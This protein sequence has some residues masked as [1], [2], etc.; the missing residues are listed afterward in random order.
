MN[1][2]GTATH[3]LTGAAAGIFAAWAMNEFQNAWLK[4][5]P[6]AGKLQTDVDIMREIA[7]RAAKATGARLSRRQLEAAGWV[8]HYGFGTTAGALY[9]VLAEKSEFVTKGFGAGFGTVFFA[10]GDAFAPEDLKPKV[11][12]SRTVS[13]IYEWLTHVVYGVALEAGRRGAL[14]GLKKLPG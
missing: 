8:L 9:A 10:I 5:A 1:K 2:E 3:L 12:D 13:E 7:R 11:N 14:I 4:V 6:A